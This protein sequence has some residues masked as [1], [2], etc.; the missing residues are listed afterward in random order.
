MQL[1]VKMNAHKAYMLDTSSNFRRCYQGNFW[2]NRK[3][4]P[5]RCSVHRHK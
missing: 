4:M 3:R 2:S 1:C 5:Y